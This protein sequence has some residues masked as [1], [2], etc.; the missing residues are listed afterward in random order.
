MKLS[1]ELEFYVANAA[2]ETVPEELTDKQRHEME[3]MGKD[4]I[5]KHVCDHAGIED[6]L[7]LHDLHQEIYKAELDFMD[8]LYKLV[9]KMPGINVNYMNIL[10]ATGRVEELNT[11]LKGLLC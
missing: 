9:C 2:F 3:L 6:A 1:N 7:E 10:A 8:T 5:W 11:Y 4:I